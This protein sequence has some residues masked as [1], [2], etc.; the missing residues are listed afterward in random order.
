MSNEP[1]YEEYVD[2]YVTTM[3]YILTQ[4]V[5]ITRRSMP[6]TSGNIGMCFPCMNGF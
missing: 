2:R 1:T 5:Y 3:P 6:M 4:V